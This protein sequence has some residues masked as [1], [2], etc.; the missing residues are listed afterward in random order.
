MKKV[1]TKEEQTR[2]CIEGLKA[3]IE[4]F[5]PRIE[6]LD[7]PVQVPDGLTEVTVGNPELAGVAAPEGVFG[8]FDD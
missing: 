5:E 8:G 1:G 3:R 7:R 6:E 2:Q 4:G